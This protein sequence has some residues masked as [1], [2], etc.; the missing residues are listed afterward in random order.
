METFSS[1]LSPLRR[2]RSSRNSV[3]IYR[4]AELSE[5]N[6][7]DMTMDMEEEVKPSQVNDITA[8]LNKDP[9][10]KRRILTYLLLVSLL[11]FLVAFLLGYITFRKSCKSC[12]EMD[13]ECATTMS[14]DESDYQIYVP[15]E[16]ELYWDDLHTMLKKY[17]DKQEIEDNIRKVSEFSHPSGSEQQ[18][19]LSRYVYQKLQSRRLNHVWTDSHYVNLP[20]PNRLSPNFVQLVEGN[21]TRELLELE[22]EEVYCAYSAQGKA[23]GGLVYAFYGREE[24]YIRLDEMNVTVK[25]N[26]VIV[27]IGQTS[28][29][30]Q[31]AVAQ[32]FGAVGVLI[33]PDPEDIPQSPRGVGILASTSFNGHVHLG[34]GDPFTPGFPSFNHTQFPPVTSSALPK[35]LAQP[36]SSKIA[37]KL[38][39]KLSGRLAPREWRG[40]LPSTLY[41]LGP[42]LKSP[43]L[44]V[45]MGVNNDMK[46][47][48]IYNVFGS[49]EGLQ[50]PD[51]YIIMGAQRDAW[52]PGAAKSGVGTAILL[53]LAH[54]FSEMTMN[55]FKPRRSLLFASWDAGEFGSVGATEWLEVG[56]ENGA[57]HWASFLTPRTHTRTHTRAHA[58]TRAHTHAHARAPLLTRA[59]AGTRGSVVSQIPF[60]GFNPF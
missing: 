21:E 55:G 56:G 41:Y 13:S 38:M 46:S 22:D 10:S 35:I 16:K 4:K 5:E 52:G 8:M 51:R 30:E 18:V 42:N 27:R 40:R 25:N 59:R 54:A 49:I 60:R 29:A 20:F 11:L 36:I 50:E 34:T 9:Q 3:S 43:G 53:E 24:D 58:R 19:V 6:P 7:S 26:I 17:L 57:K 31:V 2:Q 15:Q 14:E 44:R 12:M 47:T 45:Q 28:F 32:K 37:K 23:T 48:M 1:L 33:Y 39:N